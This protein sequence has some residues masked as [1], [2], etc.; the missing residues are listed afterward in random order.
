[1]KKKI[2]WDY[3]LIEFGIFEAHA[4]KRI[5]YWSTMYHGTTKERPHD[6]KKRDVKERPHGLSI[7]Y[8]IEFK[9]SPS[10]LYC[11]RLLLS[12]KTMIKKL[13]QFL[14]M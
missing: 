3:S 1:M 5:V 7:M 10:I 6:V 13:M 2:V 9:F 12:R 11:W 8:R 4:S 14:G